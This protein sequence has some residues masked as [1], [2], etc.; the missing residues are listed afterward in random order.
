[1]GDKLNMFEFLFF[2][3][4]ISKLRLGTCAAHAVK[5]KKKK[6]RRGLPCT[7][8]RETEGGEAADAVPEETKD[9][10]YLASVSSV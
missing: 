7:K 6:R 5:K 8:A 4:F 1:M 10:F 3:D 2:F 9:R